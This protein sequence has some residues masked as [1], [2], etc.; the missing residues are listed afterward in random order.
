M[1]KQNEQT[2][3]ENARTEPRPK[4]VTDQ[5]AKDKLGI[6]TLETQNSDRLDFHE[7]SVWQIQ[8]ALLAAYH[9]G[10]RDQR[11]VEKRKAA[12]AEAEE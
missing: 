9:A 11:E 4:V 5:I 10:R 6:A 1:P 2:A 3:T 8:D 12:E 7:L